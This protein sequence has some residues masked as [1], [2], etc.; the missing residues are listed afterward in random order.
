[1]FNALLI[2]NVAVVKDVRLIA[3]YPAVLGRMVVIAKRPILYLNL[4]VKSSIC[5]KPLE[6][7]LM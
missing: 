6:K 2:L 4:I 1:M 7:K 3:V 5:Q